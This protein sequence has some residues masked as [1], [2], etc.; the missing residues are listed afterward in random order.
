M[1]LGKTTIRDVAKA[2]SLSPTAVSRYLNRAIVLPPDSAARIEEAVRALD[3]RPNGLARNLSLG[4]SHIIGLIIPEISNP[5]FANLASAVEEVA[6]A[7]DYGVLACNTRNDVAREFSYLRL[8]SSRQLDGILLLTCQAD[9]PELLPLLE[10]NR[11]VVLVDEDIEGLIAPRVFSENRSGG[12]LAAKHLIDYG[13]RRIGFIGGPERLLSSRERFAG[14]ID[15]LKENSTPIQSEFIRFGPYTTDFG[16][17]VATAFLKMKPSPTAI[18][19]TSDYV[20]LG[21]LHAARIWEFQCQEV[22]R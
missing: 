21:V 12:Y 20:A 3:Y 10:K 11:P 9:N 5:F 15:A 16:R 22:Y 7:A 13:H 18:F 1:R 4:K 2:A 6:F 19:A 14:F 17:E 8:L